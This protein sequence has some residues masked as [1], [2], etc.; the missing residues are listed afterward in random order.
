MSQQKSNGFSFEVYCGRVIIQLWWS[1]GVNIAELRLHSLQ[2]IPFFFP[3]LDSLFNYFFHTG[4]LSSRSIRVFAD[5][6][7]LCVQA[8]RKCFCTS[9]RITLLNFPKCAKTL[10]S[11]VACAGIRSV[12]LSRAWAWK[13]HWEQNSENYVSSHFS[14]PQTFLYYRLHPPTHTHTHLQWAGTSALKE[15][16]NEMHHGASS[17]MLIGRG[18]RWTRRHIYTRLNEWRWD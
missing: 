5:A 6:T 8:G 10:L 11:P 9:V 2:R 1:E 15:V 3:P 12:Y 13:T 17:E 7:P 4:R 16:T 18:A 14:D